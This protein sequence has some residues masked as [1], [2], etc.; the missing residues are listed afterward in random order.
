M[1]LPSIQEVKEAMFSIPIDSSPGPDGFGSGF[2]QS[3]WDIV[4]L[5]VVAAV[6]DFFWGS[7]LPRFYSASY[8]VLIP[9]VPNP[10]GFEKFRP[11]SL[12]SVIYKVCSK[13]LVKRMS[14]IL[15]RVVAP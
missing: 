8:I 7:P 12:C 5:D 6:R 11:I 15:N 13:I 1:Q 14:P 4:E 2:Y 9:K 3:C 10:P